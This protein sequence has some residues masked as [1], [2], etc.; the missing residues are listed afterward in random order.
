MAQ[1]K[2]RV[3]GQTITKIIAIM[4]LAYTV[5]ACVSNPRDNNYSI[6]MQTQKEM[7]KDMVV[8]E[9]ARLAALTE[10]TKSSDPSVRNSALLLLQQRDMKSNTIHC[11]QY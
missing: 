2:S 10:M 4:L 5:S 8:M 6:C 7:S 1:N 3:M 11:S 9:A